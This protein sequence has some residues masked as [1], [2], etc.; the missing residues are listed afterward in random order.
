MGYMEQVDQWL[1]EVLKH[2]PIY[3]FDEAKRQIKEKIL[4]SYRNGLKAAPRKTAKN[5]TA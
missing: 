2:L 4:Q 1:V 5:T 3:H